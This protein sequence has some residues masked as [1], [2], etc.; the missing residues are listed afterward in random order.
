[1]SGNFTADPSLQEQQ[2][3]VI[4]KTN[5]SFLP[6]FFSV[7]E[8]SD[9][10]T[11]VESQQHPLFA[12][13]SRASKFMNTVKIK[14]ASFKRA[15]FSSHLLTKSSQTQAPETFTPTLE[16]AVSVNEP[17]PSLVISSSSNCTSSSSSSTSS[18]SA[19]A[20]PIQQQISAEKTLPNSST[21]VSE[22]QV[23]SSNQANSLSRD[24]IAL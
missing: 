15:L 11:S 14:G 16:T 3:S 1:M 8:P 7:Y 9:A 19:L 18:T 22:C 20:L 4:P 12:R 17:Q 13:S 21:N 23:N 24:K 10:K 5:K 6:S 2:Q